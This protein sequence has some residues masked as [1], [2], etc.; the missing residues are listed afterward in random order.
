MVII[1]RV[2]KNFIISKNL[3]HIGHDFTDPET[4]NNSFLKKY[5]VA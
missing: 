4:R 1:M 2:L 3:A 5:F